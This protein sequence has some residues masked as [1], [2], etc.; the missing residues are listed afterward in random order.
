M[1]VLIRKNKAHNRYDLTA[2]C[3]IIF[4]V[5]CGGLST[6]TFSTTDFNIALGTTS[7]LTL[8]PQ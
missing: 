7:P 1:Y 6:L 3:I 2:Y 8:S 4:L 5:E